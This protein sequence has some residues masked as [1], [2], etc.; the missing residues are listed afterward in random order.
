MNMRAMIENKTMLSILF[1]AFLTSF[2]ADAEKIIDK[3]Q[4]L[5][6][7]NG[8]VK[9][10]NIVKASRTPSEPQLY[11][12][13]GD[14]EIPTKLVIRNAQG[15]TALDNKIHISVFQNLGDGKQALINFQAILLVDGKQLAVSFKQQGEDLI[16]SVPEN[17]HRVE[18]RTNSPVDIEF[19]VDYRGNLQ[20]PVQIEGL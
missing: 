15:R 20:I 1:L 9:G 7:V 14:S 19:P 12:A 18:L 16:I 13:E 17:S 11:L 4:Y 8:Q 2:S 6:V 3:T 5:G 10:N